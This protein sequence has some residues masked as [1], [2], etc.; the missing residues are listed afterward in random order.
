MLQREVDG[1]VAPEVKEGD[2]QGLAQAEGTWSGVW[3]VPSE[4]LFQ[5]CGEVISSDLTLMLPSV[6]SLSSRWRGAGFYLL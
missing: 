6:G 2:V 1:D 5:G 3:F 4:V